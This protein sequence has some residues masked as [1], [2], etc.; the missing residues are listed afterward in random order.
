MGI[1]LFIWKPNW[2][3]LVTHYFFL[4][5]DALDELLSKKDESLS[6]IGEQTKGMDQRYTY[7]RN[8][9]NNPKW[10][11]MHQKVL[12]S[13]LRSIQMGKGVDCPEYENH[14]RKQ[15]APVT[16]T[17]FALRGCPLTT[18][19]TVFSIGLSLSRNLEIFGV[20][21]LLGK[22][23]TKMLVCQACVTLAF[24]LFSQHLDW[25]RNPHTS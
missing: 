19:C 24:I 12:I 4:S 11:K 17:F 8:L 2:L 13:V 15:P 3:V 22:L 20:Y 21:N 1:S 23:Q 5:G 9:L 25:F 6:P 14:S 7:F 10:H 16:D 18:A